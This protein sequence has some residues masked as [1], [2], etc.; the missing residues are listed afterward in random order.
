MIVLNGLPPPLVLI[1]QPRFTNLEDFEENMYIQS[2]LPS[3]QVKVA[4][5]DLRV[6][7][8]NPR[9]GQGDQLNQFQTWEESIRTKH[10]PFTEFCFN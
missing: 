1:T 10:N 4:V 2:L 6:I 5:C 7:V 3:G 8:G 9:L